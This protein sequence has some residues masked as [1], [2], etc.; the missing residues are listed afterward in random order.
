MVSTMSKH[1]CSV[2]LMLLLSSLL[3]PGLGAAAEIAGDIA[4]LDTWTTL[5]GQPV[6]RGWEVVDGAIHLEPSARRA[7]DIVTTVDYADFELDFRWRIGVGGNSGIKYRVRDFDGQVLGLEYQICDDSALR[8]GGLSNTSTGALYELYAPSRN[9]VLNPLDQFNHGR[10]VV[11][12]NHVEHWLNGQLIVT[13]EIGSSEW[14]RRKAQSKF[15]DVEG[16][17]ENPQGMIMLTDH[18]SEVWY[19]D[20]AIRPLTSSQPPQLRYTSVQNRTR[21]VRRANRWRIFCRR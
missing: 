9:K 11:R 21:Y 17:G 6:T 2:T 18:G 16:F 15:A 7:G 10:I 19:R 20:L 8:S 12:G 1:L 4:A 13:A 3:A 5:D 14:Y